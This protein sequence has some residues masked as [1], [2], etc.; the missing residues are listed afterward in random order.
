MNASE[1]IAELKSLG[2]E[3]WQTGGGCTALGLALPDN[4]EIL[5]TDGEDG[6]GQPTEESTWLMV[7][8]RDTDSGDEIECESRD[9]EASLARVRWLVEKFNPEPMTPGV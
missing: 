9:F 5:V 6:G 7:G 8:L 3:T 2:F 4:K 1:A